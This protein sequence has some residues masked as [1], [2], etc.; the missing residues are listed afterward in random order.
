MIMLLNS[1]LTNCTYCI[2][3]LR[4]HVG[5]FEKVSIENWC[6]NVVLSEYD[7]PLSDI[8]TKRS[9]QGDGLGENNWASSMRLYTALR[10]TPS[11]N[12]NVSEGSQRQLIQIGKGK[13]E[14]R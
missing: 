13:E 4:D 1:Q 9:C 6:L 3:V 12:E 2:T 14:I 7:G 5:T 8:R 11:R 10:M